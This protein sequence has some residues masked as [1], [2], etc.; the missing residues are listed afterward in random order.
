MR[1]GVVILLAILVSG[2]ASLSEIKSHPG[3]RSSYA[4]NR[5]Y[6]AAYKD[7]RDWAMSCLQSAWIGSSNRVDA[8]LDN[9]VER[10]EIRTYTIGVFGTQY[11]TVLDVESSGASSSMLTINKPVR[12][13]VDRDD[14]YIRAAKGDLSCPAI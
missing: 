4:I 10:G 3:E 1:K 6:R 5:P 11:H 2:C 7:L 13:L 12:S 14:I 9:D 8:F